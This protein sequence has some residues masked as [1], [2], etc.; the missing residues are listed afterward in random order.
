MRQATSDLPDVPRVPAPWSLRGSAW[1]VLLRLRRNDV[2]R[3][4]FL[5]E[6]LQ[7]SL[8]APLSVLMLVD[9]TAAPCGPYRELLF[10]PGTMRFPDGR[11][12]GSISRIVVSTWESVVNGRRNWGIPKDRADFAVSAASDRET[13]VVSAAGHE[14]CRLDFETARGPRLPLATS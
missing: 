9:Y 11:R 4:A 2:A 1:I 10:I 8:V 7:P 6:Q 14:F 5:P 13:I 12:H 3:H